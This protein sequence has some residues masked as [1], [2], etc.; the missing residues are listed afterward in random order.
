[1][2]A[3]LLVLFGVCL[4]ITSCMFAEEKLG[5]LRL[6]STSKA[7]AGYGV[8]V[9]DGHAY[10]ANNDGVVIFDIQKP[11]RPRR[12]GKI[13]TGVTFGIY[14]EHGLAYILRNGGLVIA[15]VKDPANPKKLGEHI[16]RGETHRVR[17]DSSY[18]YIASAEGLEI[19]N[20]SDPGSIIPVAQ[21][22][23]TGGAWGVDV[24]QGIAYL[25]DP[26]NGLEVIDV[27]DPS[28]PQKV[29]TVAGT[30]GAWDVHIHNDLLYVGCRDAGIK[31]LSLS[32]KRLPQIIGIFHD[33]DDG[34]A[35]GVWGDEEYLYT[36]DNFCIEVL[37]VRDPTCPHEIGEYCQV[38]GAHDIYFDG[39]YIYVAEAR[40]GLIIFEVKK[41]QR[42]FF[43]DDA[44]SDLGIYWVDTKIIEGLKSK[45]FK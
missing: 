2:R 30:K 13:P 23:S 24:A 9:D 25:A 1:M 20:I 33:D 4:I 29:V 5:I 31:I 27:A 22:N 32:D 3:K 40:K 8:H 37:D 43:S 16:C 34:Q 14:V 45:E 15:D 44:A 36:A 17:I 12:V 21:Y 19:M 28:F 38:R 39:N 6:I 42:H 26:R 10:I 11:N 18:A 35:L 41:E 7:G